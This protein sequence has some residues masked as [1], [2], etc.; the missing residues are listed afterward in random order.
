MPLRLE[1]TDAAKKLVIEPRNIPAT[2]RAIRETL[3]LT[4]E[5][6]AARL[7]VS[8]ASV[9]RWEGGKVRP[10]QVSREAIAALAEEV[11]V[12]WVEAESSGV[13][14]D[15]GKRVRPARGRKVGKNAGSA[16]SQ[17]SSDTAS[18]EKMLW[19]AAC[20]IRGERDAAKFKDYLLPLLFLKRLSDVFDDEMARLESE[21]GSA[22][23]A[24]EIAEE[25]HDLLRFYLP[26]EARWPVINNRESH[27]WPLD[28]AGRSTAP[29]DIGEHLTK[30]V[31]AVVRH[32]P[33]L[34]GVIDVVDFAGGRDGER[35]VNPAK[36]AEVIETF[37]D[38]DYRLGLADV[39]PDFLGRAYEF[40]LRKFAEGSGKSG[41]EFFTPTEVAFLMARIMRPK[42]GDKC[43]D[44]ACG[45]AGLLI[46]LQLVA[47]ELDPT[48]RVPLKL[49]G[50]ELQA[51]SYAT[52][53][54]NAI[55]HDMDIEIARGDTMIN[56]KF[57]TAS[58]QI[59]TYDIVVANPMWNQPFKPDT[60]ANDPFDR[61]RPAGGPTSGKGDWAWLQ[62]T[63]ACLNDRG[64][65][66]VVLDTGSVTRGSGA[67][68]E[69]KE[70]NIRKWFVDND[71]IEGV[72]LLPDNLF[73]NTT[74]AG[75]IVVL[76][77]DKPG[78]RRGQIVLVDASDWA[79]KGRSKNH[80]PETA[81]LAVA[82]KFLNVDTADGRVAVV[83]TSDV[84]T[85]DYS[86][87]P[88]RW[89]VPTPTEDKEVMRIETLL[90]SLDRLSSRHAELEQ[91]ILSMLASLSTGH[92]AV[93]PLNWRR[94]EI[95]HVTIP[96]STWNP[97]R[98]PR[99]SIR[100]VDVS[101]VSRETLT[102]TKET[103]YRDFDAI[104]SRARKIVHAGDTIFATI[105]PALRR[106][107]Q[108]PERLHGEI[109][110]TAF[111]VLRANP[112]LIDPDYLFF[113][114]QID[115]VV[116]GIASLATGANYPAVRGTDVLAQQIPL[117]SLADQ[118]AIVAILSA[119]RDRV[120][121]HSTQEN[122]AGQLYRVLLHGITTGRT[123]V[124]VEQSR[125]GRR[126]SELQQFAD[127][128]EQVLN[129][130]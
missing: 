77:K 42:P 11:G 65:A 85:A 47:Q 81:I 118:Q 63:L 117:P 38:P 1:P 76:S 86:L 35:D 49:A 123:R 108:I 55:I 114:M 112:D 61:F 17:V 102:I 2:L 116:N 100:Y 56:P 106:I 68:H 72:I 91:A 97:R 96:T 53:K 95:G 113:A 43:H 66:A 107:A 27:D 4:Q 7:D 74:A 125:R 122:V 99:S 84:V 71:L 70:R 119:A 13:A 6:L 28:A 121:L 130:H 101:G 37:S 124:T 44:Y 25:D 31:R 45:S 111:C 92:A 80:L 93:L 115:E 57:K 58:G 50:Q 94:M 20:S 40:L 30:A 10:Q 22:E 69:D 64:R 89:T 90:T 48:N 9:N 82:D 16:R 51:E 127:R 67:K 36:L 21:Y 32:N 103:E 29:R 87:I 34:S 79:Y 83:S 14:A 23:V 5:E 52:A 98:D 62:H 109:V 19:R 41:G 18:M 73:Y 12:D 104:P 60:F 59:D 46:K 126:V 33:S 8:F 39:Q 78:G 105:R 120:Q 129:D 110:S 88:S 3:D 54:M 128:T 24:T 75:V 26:P 15:E